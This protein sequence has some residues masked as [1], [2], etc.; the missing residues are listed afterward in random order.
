MLSGFIAAHPTHISPEDAFRFKGVW[1]IALQDLPEDDVKQAA[2]L[3]V[4]QLNRFPT[5]A[6]VR[7]A[8]YTI[9]SVRAIETRHAAKSTE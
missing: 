5:P 3:V 9:Q 1:Y 6:D 7:A 2:E 4:H 8:V